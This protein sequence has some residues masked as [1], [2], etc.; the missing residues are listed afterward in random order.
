MATAQTS[1]KRNSISLKDKLQI[2]SRI[3]TGDKQTDVCQTLS[4]PITTVNTIWRKERCLNAST[5]PP[6]YV[7]TP[8]VHV[9]PVTRM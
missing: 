5:N 7:A 4:L 1:G 2:I 3:E 8:N 9:H 6:K